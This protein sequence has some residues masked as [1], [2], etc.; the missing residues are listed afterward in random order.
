MPGLTILSTKAERIAIDITKGMI[1]H[2][3]AC[4]FKGHESNSRTRMGRLIMK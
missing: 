2:G 3:S 4:G 1:I